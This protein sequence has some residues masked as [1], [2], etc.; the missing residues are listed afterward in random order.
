MFKKYLGLFNLVLMRPVLF[1]TKLPSGNWK[2]EPVL[3][4]GVV[5]WVIAFFVSCVVFINQ[6]LPIG[7]TIWVEVTGWKLVLV[8]P[9]AVVLSF[10]FFIMVYAVMGMVLTGLLLGLFYVLG[11]LLHFGGRMMGGLSDYT[12]SLK[13]SFYS[14]AAALI[15][16]IPV[17]TVIFSKQGL[18]D[19]TNFKIGYNIVYS[20]FVVYLYGLMAIASRKIQGI[21]RWEAFVAALLPAAVLVL[22]GI[23]MS[24]AILGKLQNW[25]I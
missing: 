14:S 5:A 13:A 17:L 21:E 7:L 6:M 3:F 18:V 22:F 10:M 15:L 25:V 16:I 9:V 11:W 1:F 24:V 19:F 2:E 20:L 12:L 23:V 4:C 8:A